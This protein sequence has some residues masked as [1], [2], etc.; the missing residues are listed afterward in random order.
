MQRRPWH[1]SAEPWLK[2][3]HRPL[4]PS[5]LIEGTGPVG[6]RLGPC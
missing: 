2:N 1:K 4:F 6:V 3:S 5:G